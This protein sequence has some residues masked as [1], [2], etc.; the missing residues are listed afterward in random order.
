MITPGSTLGVMGGGQLGRMFAIAARRM[1][2]R[3]HVFDPAAGGPASQVTDREVN[4]DYTDESA[5]DR[6][7]RDVDAVTVEFENIPARSLAVLAD[8][9]PV[10][11][12]AEVLLICQNREREK[13]FLAKKGYPLAP[14]AVVDSSDSLR[15]GLAETGVPGVLKTAAFGYDGKGQLRIEGESDPERLW[16]EFGA[17]RAVLEKW[18][19]H[20]SELSVICGGSPNFGYTCFP[21]AENVHSRHILDY[22][23]VPARIEKTILD[24]AAEIAHSIAR[25][26]DLTGLLAVEFFL[27]PKGELLVNEL[28]PRPHNSGHYTFDACVTSQFEQQVRTLC[29]LPPGSSRLLSPVVMVNLLGDLWHRG[30]PDWRVVLDEPDAKLHL[31]GKAEA[32]PG[33]K[34]G[35]FCVLAEDRD[36]ALGKALAIRERLSID[37]PQD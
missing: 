30:D 20:E 37:M 7:A 36:E 11:P 34:M 14:F 19:P 21:A 1:G 22:S 27:T 26:L 5:L 24:R 4:A 6:F 2:Y 13:T 29:G 32:R 15:R 16:K 3:V 12:A 18:I 10:H 8:R 28:A 35:H 31:Y 23:I 33:R 25:E 17:P 9:R